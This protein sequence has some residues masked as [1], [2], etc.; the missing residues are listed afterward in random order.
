MT[1]DTTTHYNF[2]IPN[3]DGEDYQHVDCIRHPI[4]AIDTKI[5][6]HYIEHKTRLDSL[7]G[8]T[9]NAVRTHNGVPSKII[10][11]EAI[12]SVNTDANGFATFSH[13]AG[14]DPSMILIM[15]GSFATNSS[16]AI[17]TDLYTATTFRARFGEISGGYRNAGPTGN[18]IAFFL[19]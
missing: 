6:D 17:G 14:F 4:S 8:P 1:H 13:A 10:H 3:E 9:S 12:E 7:D 16:F 18:L 2:E 5:Y 19:S 11:Y 15:S